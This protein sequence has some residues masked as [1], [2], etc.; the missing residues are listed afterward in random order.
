MASVKKLYLNPRLKGSYSG[1]ATFY[2]NRHP[3]LTFKQVKEELQKLSEYYQFVQARKK[4]PRR[5]VVS[6]FANY[7]YCSDLIVL[8]RKYYKDNKPFKNIIIFVDL[9]SRQL[10]AYPIS[11][12]KPVAII[13]ALRK[14]LKQVKKKP[15]YLQTDKGT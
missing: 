14:W 4:F 6:H 9:F 15:S 11:S 2:R 12:K 5:Q 10:F 13:G 1:A 8:P 3:K 7:I